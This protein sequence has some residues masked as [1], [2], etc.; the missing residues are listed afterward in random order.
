[1]FVISLSKHIYINV[2]IFLVYKFIMVKF[3]RQQINN[4]PCLCIRYG[5][6]TNVEDISFYSP[7]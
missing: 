5:L 6:K 4:S 1:M 2:Y 7:S 3:V